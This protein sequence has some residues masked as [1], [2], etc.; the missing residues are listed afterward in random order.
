MG[1]KKNNGKALDPSYSGLLTGSDIKLLLDHEIVIHPYDK[2]N[3]T[4]VGY[5]LTFSDFIY[6]LSTHTFVEIIDNGKEP[7]FFLIRPNET[8][9]VLT[10]ETIWVSKHI[11]GTFHSKV[12][13]VTKGLGHVSTTL[14]PGWQGQLLIP[15]NN[16]TKHE[17]KIHI[18]NDEGI[19]QSF[20]T[21]VL[22]RSEKGT[23]IKHNNRPARLDLLMKIVREG[24][25]GSKRLEFKELLK[26]IERKVYGVDSN[27]KPRI[28]LNNPSDLKNIKVDI[29]KF[30]KKC[31]KFEKVMRKHQNQIS[32]YKKSLISDNIKKFI[33][34]IAI[35]VLVVALP[36]I[37]LLITKDETYIN[38]CLPIAA[39][40]VSVSIF[41]INS[42]RKKF[43]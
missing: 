39:M 25:P 4:P 7:E 38:I 43:I 2:N 22:H 20:I 32:I 17:R 35:C 14:D 12:S 36:F 33:I 16:T 40:L 6:S 24:K 42:F 15:I 9:L 37:F 19:I 26:D 21:L 10:R 18:M 11:G 27:N 28:D 31:S 29:K 8:V 23:R 13:L 3:L 41:V 1:N 34:V 5:N 30:R